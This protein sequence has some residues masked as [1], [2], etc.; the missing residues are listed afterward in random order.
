MMLIVTGYMYVEPSSV[1][2]FVQ[3]IQNLSIATRQRDGN[4][5]YDAAVDD[6]L[7]GRLLVAE[8]WR[9]QAALTAH[10]H[11]TDT[12]AFV[13]RWGD[14]IRGEILKYDVLRKR[15]LMDE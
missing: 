12:M 5:S 8:R 1:A 4:L 7:A 11:A 13:G 3:D 10:L 2:E 6:P 9:D 15:G 14:T